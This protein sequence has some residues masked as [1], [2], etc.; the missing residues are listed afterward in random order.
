MSDKRKQN[1]KYLTYFSRVIDRR[2]G[3]LVG[4]LADLTTGGALLISDDPH[5]IGEELRL[6]MDLPDSYA[7]RKHIDF[8]GQVAWCRPDEDPNF[9]KTGIHFIDIPSKDLAIIER[10]LGE[11][12]FTL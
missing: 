1:R 12:G 6:R 11:F 4:Y 8:N 3:R 2:N 9:H 7:P 5:A 10:V